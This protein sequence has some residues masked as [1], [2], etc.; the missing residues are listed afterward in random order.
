MLTALFVHCAQKCHNNTEAPVK[1]WRRVA[2]G[3]ENGFRQRMV[4]GNQPTAGVGPDTELTQ[5]YNH[6]RLHPAFW[7]LP[8]TCLV[9]RSVTV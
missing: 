3:N 5:P 8:P 2:K 6:Y 1:R 9:T 7:P 4:E